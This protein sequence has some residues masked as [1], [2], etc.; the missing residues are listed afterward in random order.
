M[1]IRSQCA[2]RFPPDPTRKAQ[3]CNS[4]LIWLDLIR[5]QEI[6][7]DFHYSFHK[8]LFWNGFLKNKAVDFIFRGQIYNSPVKKYFCLH[9]EKL[10]W[11]RESIYYPERTMNRKWKEIKSIKILWTSVEYYTTIWNASVRDEWV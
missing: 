7:I 10:I 2:L 3:T 11:P 9:G 4:E 5:F 1:K 8:L 6:S